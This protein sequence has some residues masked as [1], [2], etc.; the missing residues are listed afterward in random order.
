MRT[1]AAAMPSTA[2]ADDV[3]LQVRD[4]KIC[5]RL[6]HGRLL[7]VVDTANLTVHRNQAIGIIGESGSGKT[8]LCRSLIGT[9]ARRGAL[10]TAGSIVFNR[11]ELT[12]ATEGVWRSIRG[13]EIG[14]VPQSSL[15]GLNPLL[16]IETQLIES[17]TAVQ[18][19]SQQE[20]GREAIELL[21]KVRIPRAKQVLRERPYQLS[22]GMRQRVMIASAIAQKPKLL[23]ADEP[24]T[25]LDVTIQRE[26]L[27]LIANLR[28][29]LRMAVIVV[30]HDL[31]IIEEIGD[32][33]VV[34]YAGMAVEDGP[35][36]VLAHSPRHPYTRALRVSRVDLATPG[37]EIEAIAGSPVSVGAWPEG[38]RFWPR[39]PLADDDC[40]RPPHPGLRP[41][42]QQLSAC[43]HA[44]RMGRAA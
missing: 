28:R 5:F 4:L 11:Q 37:C 8:M 34:M 3:L 36:D 16:D 33:V 18:S 19:I 42:G 6:E 2:L 9:L 12:H 38:C 13:R 26:I 29:E 40:Q 25:A 23:I 1:I 14:Y 35:V 10:V 32:S 15:A 24:T 17:I 39:C 21:E 30:S 22:G 31:A 27:T 41:V 7:P 43:I 20:A 44:D